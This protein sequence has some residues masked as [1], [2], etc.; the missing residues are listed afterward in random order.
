MHQKSQLGSMLDKI[1]TSTLVSFLI[2]G[3]IVSSVLFYFLSK[4]G[5]GVISTFTEGAQITIFDSLY[6]SIIT[7]SSLGYGDYRPV[8]AGRIVAALE[9]IYGLFFLAIIVSKLA[10]ERTSTL[11]KLVYASDTQRR[12]LDFIETTNNRNEKMREAI[13]DNDYY[14]ASDLAHFNKTA[15]S[16][17]KQFIT[18]HLQY[19]DIGND[20]VTRQLVRL[21]KAVGDSTDIAHSIIRKMHT[22]SQIHVRIENYLSKAATL[23]EHIANNYDRDKISQIHDHIL[24]QRAAFQTAINSC[25]GDFERLRGTVPYEITSALLIRVKQSL[26][27][28][29]WPDH[30]HKLIAKDLKVSNKLAQR[31]ISVL[32]KDGHFP[33]P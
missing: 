27:M 8:G 14:T 32:M 21:I 2:S 9:V 18:Y 30:V 31:A 29:P 3:V 4:I 26:P 6:F 1:K 25:D 7:V 16:T 10:S 33:A 15:F 12:L 24:R 22:D 13:K 28:R 17:Y 19:G 23:S 20:W 5:Q 11:I